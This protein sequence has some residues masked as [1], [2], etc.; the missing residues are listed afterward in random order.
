MTHLELIRWSHVVVVVVMTLAVRSIFF[1]I[2]RWTRCNI[3]TV[4]KKR[5]SVKRRV[6]RLLVLWTITPADM[7]TAATHTPLHNYS[8]QSFAALLTQLT[9]SSMTAHLVSF[10]ST[11]LWILT[12]TLSLR[13]C[14]CLH[15]RCTLKYQYFFFF[16]GG[17]QE[18]N[19]SNLASPVL[20]YCDL[21]LLI[22]GKYRPL[23]SMFRFNSQ[24]VQE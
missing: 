20:P 3:E 6:I 22:R 24:W 4:S 10:Y 8:F 15:T 11:P 2:T 9:F 12:H 18:K 21:P 7:S 23:W 1:I 5:V 16:G 19:G 17:G 14:V 13:V